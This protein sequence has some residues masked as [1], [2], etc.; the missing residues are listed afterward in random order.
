MVLLSA[1]RRWHFR[2]QSP[3]REFERRSGLSPNTICKSL[4]I[5]TVKPNFQVPVRPSKLDRIAEQSSGW[6]RIE[7]G[8][9]RKQLLTVKL[10]HAD[11]VML[12]NGGSS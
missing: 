8:K 2:Q 3:V 6:L 4:R 7:A 10:M 11:L 5:D 9:S 1:S 12:D